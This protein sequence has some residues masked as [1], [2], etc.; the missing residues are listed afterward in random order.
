MHQSADQQI[1]SLRLDT[2]LDMAKNFASGPKI[3]LRV[4]TKTADYTV[5]QADSGTIFTNYGD[6]GA[7]IFTL[8]VNPTKGFC[9]LFVNAV[10]QS[11]N[12][13]AGTVDTLIT[14]NDVAADSV[15]FDQSSNKIG[16]AIFVF[17]DGN[18]YYALQMT[19]GTFGV[20]T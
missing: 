2:L 7:I 1:G 11:L 8:P 17:S 20:N 13:T 10:D 15:D 16:Q 5:T 6:A 9:A 4:Q 14:H 18:A 3:L 12:V 19:A